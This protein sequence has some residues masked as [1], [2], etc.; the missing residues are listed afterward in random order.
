MFR[1]VRWFQ[2]PLYTVY[3]TQITLTLLALLLDGLGA[4]AGGRVAL[5]ERE[6][7]R[8]DVGLRVALGPRAAH[9]PARLC[10]RGHHITIL[11]TKLSNEMGVG[12]WSPY[13]WQIKYVMCDKLD[14]YTYLIFVVKSMWYQKSTFTSKNKNRIKIP[15]VVWEIRQEMACRLL[16]SLL[17][18]SLR[19]CE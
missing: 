19:T 6:H 1:G 13:Q 14:R 17:L 11:S 15:A 8:A 2:I 16:P 10:G 7:A 12:D 5:L 4:L 18:S 3:T 9:V